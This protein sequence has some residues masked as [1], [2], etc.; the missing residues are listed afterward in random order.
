MQQ[1]AHPPTEEKSSCYAKSASLSSRPPLS[2]PLRLLRPRHWRG[3]TAAMAAMGAM[4]LRM[5][6][7]AIGVSAIAAGATGISAPAAVGRAGVIPI[8]A[9]AGNG[10]EKA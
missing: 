1:N 7:G 4:A 6:A 3:G 5:A 8:H 2:A 10:G 9:A